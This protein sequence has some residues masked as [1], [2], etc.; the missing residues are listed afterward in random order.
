MGKMECHVIEDLLPSY[1][2]D[3]CSPETKQQVEEHLQECGAC[4]TRLEQ[5]G[6]QGDGEDGPGKPVGIQDIRPFRKISR[7]MKRNRAGKVA[8]LILLLIVCSVFG[9][10]TAGQFFPSLDCPSYDSLMY[11]FRAKEI[12]RK[13]VAGDENEIRE[14][15]IGVGN[16]YGSKLIDS[17]RNKLINDVARHLAESR[18][19]FGGAN[20][21][22]HVDD[23]SYCVEEYDSSQAE[24]PQ[25]F[26]MEYAYYL[27]NLTVQRADN[28]IYMSIGFYNRNQ[29]TFHIRTEGNYRD[30]VTEDMDEDLLEY[31]VIDIN[32]Y[33]DYY[34]FSCFG[35][36]V[37]TQL[38]NG[39]ISNQ[40]AEMLKKNNAFGGDWYTYYLTNDCMKPG[41]EKEG[42]YCT[43]YSQQTAERMY[44]VIAGCQ[45]NSFRMTDGH[46]NETE[47]K[48]DATL[49]WEITDLNGKK[50]MMKKAFY[51]GPSGYEPADDTEMI[52]AEEGFDREIA[53]KMETVFDQ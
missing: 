22:I 46:Y 39:R 28:K 24:E 26:G 25:P 7:K 2:D 6:G 45:S 32:K 18:T 23:V 21:A 19:A 16:D 4:R 8:A 31:Q 50:C 1:V 44:P 43:E 20:A 11:R 9:V 14:V 34:L 42:V 51:F 36:R 33:L 30:L 17:E 10:L 38:L 48:F 12:A 40:N 52:F 37:E 47:G 3:I 13:I 29:Y 27:V 35:E 15:L 5:M 41:V 53:Q 49:Y